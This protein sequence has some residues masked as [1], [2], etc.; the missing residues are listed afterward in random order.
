M[1][2]SSV[3]AALCIKKKKKW[4]NKGFSIRWNWK[5]NKIFLAQLVVFY[6]ASFWFAALCD[7]VFAACFNKSFSWLSKNI[8][9]SCHYQVFPYMFKVLMSYTWKFYRKEST[10]TFSERERERENDQKKV[11]LIISTPF[12]W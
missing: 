5:L 6:D 9:S 1:V 12:Y 11:A 3:S 2:S 10:N 8:S 7:A 4:C